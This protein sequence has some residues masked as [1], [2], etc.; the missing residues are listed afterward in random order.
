[1]AEDLLD[2]DGAAQDE[3]LF[4]FASDLKG[5]RSLEVEKMDL[6]LADLSTRSAGASQGGFPGRR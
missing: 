3:Q 5:D 1:M 2:E 6:M 4:K